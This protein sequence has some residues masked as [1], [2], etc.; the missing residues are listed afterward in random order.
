M[1]IAAA[2]TGRKNLKRKRYEF[3]RESSW[4]KQRW[5]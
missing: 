4:K 2:R 5:N 3:K 1:T